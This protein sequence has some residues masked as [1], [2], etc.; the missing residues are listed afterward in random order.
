LNMVNVEIVLS[1]LPE[2]PRPVALPWLA[3]HVRTTT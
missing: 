2:P 3:N 1:P